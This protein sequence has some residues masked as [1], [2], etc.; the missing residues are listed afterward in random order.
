MIQLNLLPDVKMAYVKA[1]R[2][3]RLV[4]TV[5]ILVTIACIAIFVLFLVYNVYQKH[6]ISRLTSQISSST[7]E[8][9]G[10]KDINQV[11]TVQKQLSTLN[12]L[13]STKINA[14][15][16]F[17]TY[18]DELIPANASISNL[19][20]D[21]N[22]DTVS[23]QGAAD[24]LTTVDTLVDTLKFTTYKSTSVPTATAAFSEVLLSSFG[25]DTDPGVAANQQAGY[26]VTFSFDPSIFA[27]SS[28]PTLQVPNKVTTR[29]DL[30]Q[31]TDLFVTSPTTDKTTTGSK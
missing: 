1:N 24:S 18:L 4:I 27:S 22:A 9:E 7:N 16:F 12:T 29:S 23:I 31:P 10:K 13:N 3:R 8:L 5:S 30:A 15:I 19:S 26:T 25:L 6:H 17:S 2:L 21:Y 28:N 14:G 11:L 20:I